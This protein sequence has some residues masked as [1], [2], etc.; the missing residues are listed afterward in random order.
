MLLRNAKSA[1]AMVVGLVACNV[2]VA[3]YQTLPLDPAVRYGRLENGLTY[4]IRH[5]EEP[6]ERANFYIAQ[7]VGS[8]QEEEE[9][10]GL[11]HFLEHMC[12]NGTKHFPGNRIVDYCESIG[13]K[14]GENLNAYTSTDETVYN[15][16][17]VP[18]LTENID[19]CLLILRDW[20]D[21]LLLEAA[22]IDKE[23]GVIHEEWRMRSSAFMRILNRNLETL[24]PGSR[25]GKR[26]PIG[27]M[28]VVDNFEPKFL[29]EYYE[30]WYRPDLQAI[31]V[32]GDVD[33]DDIEKRI[34]NGFSDIKMPENAAKFETYEVPVNEESIYVIDKDKEMS[35]PE[36]WLCF[37]GEP[38][39]REMKGTVASYVEQFVMGTICNSLNIRLDEIAKMEDCPFVYAGVS[40]GEYLISKTCDALQL[41]VVPKPGQN[42][43][44][45]DAAMR[46]IERARRFGITPTE[47]S[48]AKDEILSQ[49]EKAYENRD[50]QKNSYYINEY[51]RHFIDNA[52]SPGLEVD[53][54]TFKMLATA[55]SPQ[56]IS[57]AIASL[58]ASVEKNFVVFGLYPDK[59]DVVLPTPEQL[60]KAVDNARNAELE[61][62]MDNVNDEP[63]VAELPAMGKI[64]KEEAFD[65]GYTVWTLQNGAR[66]FFRQTDF[67]NSEVL[68][69]ARSHGGRMYVDE[70]DDVTA[71]VFNDIASATGIGSFNSSDLYKKMSGKQVTA[72][73]SLSWQSDNLYGNSTP[74]DLRTLFE[75]IYLRFQAPANDVDSYNMLINQ[76]RTSLD[77][78][79]KQPTI[80]FNDSLMAAVYGNN[81]RTRRFKKADIDNVS[82]DVYRKM[83]ESRFASVGDFDFFFTGAFNADSLKLF[84]EQ[85]IAPLPGVKSREIRRKAPK[86]VAGSL[87]NRFTR[88]METPQAY[89]CQM[90]TGDRNY[91]VRESVIM[92]FLSSILDA[93]YVK[94]IR[95]EAGFAYSV[96]VGGVQDD[97]QYV[98]QI[99][100]PFTPSKCDSVLLLMRES[101]ND[102]ARNGVT[103]EELENVRKFQLKNYADSQRTNSYW[104]SLLIDRIVLDRTN[105]G[106]EDFVKAISSDDIRN[107]INDVILRDNNCKTIIML[108]EDFTETE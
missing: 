14:F 55:L 8:V 108:P 79:E 102:I 40:Y 38:L 64:S 5:N 9:Q 39:S 2:A 44:A 49:V 62:Y 68:M 70:N 29:R 99:L 18:V 81:P 71:K 43:E 78:A 58:T 95:E 90:W 73:V 45:V 32:V 41:T 97:E 56:V 89:V 80:A 37:K 6:R 84:V 50:K 51:V 15:I 57:D 103:S 93:R 106:Y 47:I 94:T 69:S 26:M 3:Q 96:N 4:Y 27:L 25:Y 42:A 16:N 23:R 60:K 20:S 28:S 88:Q 34:I 75:L 53:F 100:A 77:N 63:F 19:S 65:H 33:V 74:K 13:V 21:G 61:A 85:Y 31:I 91:T 36:I 30:K 101:I 87:E 7:M 17:D 59:D 72:N 22:E 66:V 76:M 82:Y 107:Y 98:M 35:S 86:Y 11:A 52:P 54:Q 67:N 24:Y 92:K 104:Q 105:E 48:R 10:R 83:Y 12:F 1:F 46:E